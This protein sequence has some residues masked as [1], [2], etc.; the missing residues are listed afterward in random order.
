MDIIAIALGTAIYMGGIS[1]GSPHPFIG[2][3]MAFAVVRHMRKQILKQK[4]EK[5]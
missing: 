5:E 1:C 4:K 3:C 2:G